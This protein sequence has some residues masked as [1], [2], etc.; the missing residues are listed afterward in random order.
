MVLDKTKKKN[1]KN[2]EQKP[3]NSLKKVKIIQ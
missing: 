3:L 1:K 2:Q